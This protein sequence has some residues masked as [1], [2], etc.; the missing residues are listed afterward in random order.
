M[1]H[2]SPT[3]RQLHEDA[4]VEPRASDDKRTIMPQSSIIFRKLGYPTFSPSAFCRPT[5]LNLSISFGPAP[6][7]C[8]SRYFIIR[9]NAGHPRLLGSCSSSPPHRSRLLIGNSP[10]STH[11]SHRPSMHVACLQ[12]LLKVRYQPRFV[13]RRQSQQPNDVSFGANGDLVLAT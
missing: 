12:C 1:K 3:W 13:P 8:S 11:L 5:S 2:G 9:V 4:R 7:I 10:F 6:P